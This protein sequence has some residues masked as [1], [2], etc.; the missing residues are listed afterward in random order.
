MLFHPIK[1]FDPNLPDEGT[2]I[3]ID[4]QKFYFDFLFHNPLNVST[5]P[6]YM[7]IDSDSI[8]DT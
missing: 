4:N 5:Q 3:E 8:I 2:Y 7:T 1:G 6:Y